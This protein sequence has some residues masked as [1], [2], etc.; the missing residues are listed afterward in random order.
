MCKSIIGWHWHL[1][2]NFGGEVDL[3]QHGYKQMQ[4][5]RSVSGT[6]RQSPEILAT[7]LQTLCLTLERRMVRQQFFCHRL[8]GWVR[9]HNGKCYED[10]LT[11]SIPMQDGI[12]IYE[13]LCARMRRYEQAQTRPPH[14]AQHRRAAD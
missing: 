8:Q 6:Q 4:A 7:I 1:R 3:V 9:Y 12:E 11:F 13:L 10:V 14:I 2:L 5:I